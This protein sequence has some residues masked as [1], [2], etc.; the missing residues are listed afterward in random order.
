MKR[1][2]LFAGTTKHPRGGI[3]DL[4]AHSDS[5]QEIRELA[6]SYDVPYRWAHIVDA[7]ETGPDGMAIKLVSFGDYA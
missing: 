3:D 5:F 1:Y 7:T 4:K 6:E 2:L